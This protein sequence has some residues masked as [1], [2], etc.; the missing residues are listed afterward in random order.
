MNNA[1][2]EEYKAL[3]EEI[4]RNESDG[5]RLILFIITGTISIL[6]LTETIPLWVA[7]IIFQVALIIGWTQ[8]LDSLKLRIRL[9]TYIQ[10][11]IEPQ[12][13]EI[14]WETRYNAFRE[15]YQPSWLRKFYHYLFNVYVLLFFSGFVFS[16][17]SFYQLWKKSCIPHCYLF[18]FLSSLLILNT[19]N[20]FLTFTCIRDRFAHKHDDECEKVWGDVREGERQ[21]RSWIDSYQ[22]S[23]IIPTSFVEFRFH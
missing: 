6:G 4:K 17:W 5:L 20:A 12:I 19:I 8:Y 10:T 16:G 13:P 23:F 18:I 21:N 2:I 9:S 11:F 1:L 14:N 15:L 7:A 22:R 3:R